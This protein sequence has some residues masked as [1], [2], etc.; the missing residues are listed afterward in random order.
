MCPFHSLFSAMS[1]SFYVLLLVAVVI[2]L[3]KI[4]CKHSTKVLSGVIYQAPEG[5]DVPYEENMC[6]RYISF[7]NNL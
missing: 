3:F 7:T 1:F 6:V 4:S 5:W 2:L